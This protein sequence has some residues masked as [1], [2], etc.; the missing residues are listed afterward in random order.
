MIFEES[1]YL[2]SHAFTSS[3]NKS[4]GILGSFPTIPTNSP[5]I[6]IPSVQDHSITMPRTKDPSITV[7][8]PTTDSNSSDQAPLTSSPETTDSDENN[9]TQSS[10][11]LPSPSSTP[12]LKTK[13]LT[14]IYYQTQPVTH[15]PPFE[16]FL[17]NTN[18]P[19]ELVSFSH[20]IKDAQWLQAMKK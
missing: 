20:A 3:Q 8:S 15:H 5:S 10:S 7:P 16:C 1:I 2:Y 19:C 17:T 6:M 11:D 18:T 12:P 9:I 13:S 14:E 4:T